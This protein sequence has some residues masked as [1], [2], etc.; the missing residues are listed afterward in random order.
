MITAVIRQFYKTM[1]VT[2]LKISL[3]KG[4]GKSRCYLELRMIRQSVAEVSVTVTQNSTA[5]PGQ[6]WG[7]VEAGYVYIYRTRTDHPFSY[8]EKVSSR[9][10]GTSQDG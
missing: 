6:I 9:V 7:K 3:A 8:A 2:F 1:Y 4:Q 10:V 5:Q